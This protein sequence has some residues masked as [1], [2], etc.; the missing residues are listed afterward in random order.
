MRSIWSIDG[1]ITG[2]TTPDQ[3]GHGSNGKEVILDTPHYHMLFSWWGFCSFRFC[4]FVLFLFYPWH[5]SA[6]DA[7]DL[8]WAL[9]TGLHIAKDAAKNHVRVVYIG[10]HSRM[11]NFDR[12]ESLAGWLVGWLILYNVE[13]SLFICKQVSSN[14]P[15]YKFKHSNMASNRSFLPIEGT[16]TGTNTT[17]NG[18][19]SNGT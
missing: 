3:S 9:P 17:S 6:Y 14:S 7:V 4:F 2:T 13:V 18:P 12:E 19:G 10:R 1:S 16:L 8:F 11:K 5:L 15:Q